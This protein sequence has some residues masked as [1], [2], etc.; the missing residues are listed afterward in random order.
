[1]FTTQEVV[2]WAEEKRK[3]TVGMSK[4]NREVVEVLRRKLLSSES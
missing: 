2:D 4:N 3:M 1:M